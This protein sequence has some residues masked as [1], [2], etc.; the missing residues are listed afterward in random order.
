MNKDNIRKTRKFW[1]FKFRGKIMGSNDI[2]M[3][4]MLLEKVNNLILGCQTEWHTVNVPKQIDIRNF[5]IQCAY[6]IYMYIFCIK[7]VRHAYL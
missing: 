6:H 2:N 4:T 7:R 1:G 5:G 3:Q